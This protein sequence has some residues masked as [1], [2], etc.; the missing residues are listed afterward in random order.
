MQGYLRRVR[1]LGAGQD[2]ADILAG[3]AVALA[4]LGPPAVRARR[5]AL[6][7]RSASLPAAALRPPPALAGPDLLGVVHEALLADGHRHRRG[8][9]YTPRAVAEGL[10]AEARHGWGNPPAPTVCDPAVGGG[11][12]LLAAARALVALGLDRRRIV[13][14]LLWGTD[15]DP[16]AVLVTEAALWLWAG[17]DGPPVRP[18]HLVVA[19]SLGAGPSLWP[20]GPSAGFDLVVGNPPFGAQRSHRTARSPAET[21]RLRQSLGPAVRGYADTASLF[22]L[23]AAGLVADGGRVA[24]VQPESFLAARD[25]APVRD[26]LLER[27]PLVG[28]WVAAE[29]VFAAGV[30]V[31][32]PIFEASAGGRG[33]SPSVVRRTVGGCFRRLPPATVQWAGGAPSWTGLAAAA[34]GVPTIAGWSTA[35]VL[36]DRWVG[37][38][39]FRDQY[40]GLVDHVAEAAD[41]DPD[42]RTAPLVTTG[43]V[44]PLAHRWGHH[45]A[46]FAKRRWAAPVVD[47][48]TLAAADPALARWVADRLVP[49]VLVATQTRVVEA[50]VDAEGALVP[51]VP[52]VA[53]TAAGDDLDPWLVAAALSAPPVTAWA[54]THYGGAGLSSRVLKL[55]AHQVLAVPLPAEVGPWYEV[56]R[57]WRAAS[58]QHP[59]PPQWRELLDEAGVEL[60]TAYGLDAEHP[61]LAWWR[62]RLHG[63]AD[64][65][66]AARRHSERPGRPGPATWD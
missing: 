63:N 21:A 13:T 60:C 19:D 62:T 56:A 24:L 44:E 46:R 22:L 35:G 11:A 38:A 37:T 7:N 66:Y 40:Y 6:L 65:G 64:L 9:H 14:D 57:R 27:G 32:A 59:T 47:L 36:G 34:R 18:A 39:G 29:P 52:L 31:C 28:L 30:E 10:V 55:A 15:L 45:P 33:R 61:V 20:D 2:P 50:L 17:E 25:A 42:H 12:F 49:K 41:A 48:D 54:L 1:E 26:A 23:T 4:D 53:V 43:L 51:S 58:G 8:V 3:V 16:L 5:P